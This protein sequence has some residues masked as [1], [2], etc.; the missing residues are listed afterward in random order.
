MLR[1][2]LAAMAGL[3]AAQLPA[4]AARACAAA[5]V[6]AMDVSGSVD[7]VEHRLQTHGL[8]QALRDPEVTELLVT[9]RVAVAVLQWSAADDQRLAL[10]WRRM[11]D[12]AAVAALADAV[13]R[14]PRAFTARQT[15]PGEALI[16]AAGLFAGVP[17]CGRR[18]IDLSGDGAR[19][20]GMNPATVA[21]WAEARGI[22][23]NA[24]A[25]EDA[26]RGVPITS[27]F[28]RFV[29]SRDGFVITARGFE[30][31]ARAMRLK[32]LRELAPPLG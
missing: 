19:N 30:D 20:D 12:D 1:R 26:G 7:P 31:F 16:A 5:L 3:V 18:I 17:D 13:E 25:I 4:G 10:P 11:H 32:L 27:Y 22:E 9:G 24:L 28:N 8:A 21:R 2:V 14:L 6:L 23:I 15:A 29:I